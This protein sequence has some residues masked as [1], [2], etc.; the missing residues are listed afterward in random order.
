[1]KKIL[2]FAVIAAIAA[3][4]F[5]TPEIKVL[6]GDYGSLKEYIL[7]QPLARI[8][9]AAYLMGSIPFGLIIAKVFCGIDPREQGSKNVGSTNVARLCGFKYGV[10]TLVFDALKGLLPT[11]YA[12][13]V[14]GFPLWASLVALCAL[15]GHLFS[16]FLDF[17]GG[18]AVATT[19]G[20]FIPLSF[21]A[22]LV[23]ALICV[24]VIWRSGYVSL[25]SL[26]LATC[27]P[28]TLAMF[29]RF[30][31]IPFALAVMLLIFVKHRGN[32]QR[33]MAG[34]EKSFLKSRQK[35]EAKSEQMTKE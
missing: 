35:D 14:L 34:E 33:L 19:V 2:G 10:L 7:L 18:K 5:L 6:D 20:V 16:I 22:L 4:S 12:L 32:I 30:E 24:A 27:L 8:C 9:L 23:S 26:T 3:A 13:H 17:K 11:W 15:V 29:G 28:I 31:L 1:M 25:G 21:P